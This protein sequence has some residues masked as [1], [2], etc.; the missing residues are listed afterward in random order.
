MRNSLVTVIAAHPKRRAMAELLDEAVNATAIVY[1][2]HDDEWDTMSRAWR[3]AREVAVISG[4]T[5]ALVLQ[6]D[7]VPIEGFTR[8]VLEAIDQHPGNAIS[9]YLGRKKPSRW[10][11]NVDFAVR[12]AEAEGYSWLRASHLLHGVALVLPVAWIDGMLTWCRKSNAPYD[13][14]VGY[15][16]RHVVGSLTYYPQPSLVDHDDDTPSLVRH[17]DDRLTGTSGRVAYRFG[18]PSW[19]YPDVLDIVTPIGAPT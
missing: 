6:D 5:H 9:L 17:A 19:E 7:A 15:F 3:A 18:R 2:E 14:R 13:E 1:D 16:L 12:V 8:T 11:G 4:A 10:V